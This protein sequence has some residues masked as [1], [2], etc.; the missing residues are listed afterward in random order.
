[1]NTVKSLW[2]CVQYAERDEASASN[3]QRWIELATSAIAKLNELIHSPAL[4]FPKKRIYQTSCDQLHSIRRLL[5]EC[6][7]V[8]G[9]LQQNRE[10]LHEDRVVWDDTETAF[11]SDIKNAVITNLKC[12]DLV[13]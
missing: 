9:E 6:A 1:M 11:K 13:A 4:S 8:G 3:I 10:E 5:S 2:K 7:R 12:S